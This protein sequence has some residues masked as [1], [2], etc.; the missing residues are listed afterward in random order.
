MFGRILIPLDEQHVLLIPRQAVQRVGQLELVN[1]VT[2]RS[3]IRRAVRLGRTVGEDIEVLSGLR[4]GE[5]VQV[6]ANTV[7]TSGDNHG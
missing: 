3:I 6:Q 1:V 2:P 7:K 4:A 5:S